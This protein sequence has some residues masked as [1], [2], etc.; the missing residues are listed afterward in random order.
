[1]GGDT[2]VKAPAKRMA[3]AFEEEPGGDLLSHK[4]YALSSAQLRFTVLFGMGR[5]GSGAL[6]PP[7]VTCPCS[8]RRGTQK[9]ERVVIAAEL[10][11][12]VIGSSLTGN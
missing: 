6:W 1:M 11:L 4:R 9:G 5:G 3:G 8:A 7:S 12:K 10:L 2:K